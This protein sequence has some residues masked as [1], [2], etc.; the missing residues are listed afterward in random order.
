MERAMS[1]L[2]KESCDIS[3]LNSKIIAQT[4]KIERLC[5]QVAALREALSSNMA[6]IKKSQEILRDQLIGPSRGLSDHRALNALHGVF[7]GAAQRAALE[8][9]MA[10]LATG[11]DD[12]DRT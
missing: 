6:I 7:D 10:A 4:E 2:Y 5:A 12:Y 9:A 8:K 3:R 1:D 11:G